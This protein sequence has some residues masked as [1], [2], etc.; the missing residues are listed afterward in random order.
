MRHF[1]TALLSL[2]APV[3]VAA[4]SRTFERQWPLNPDGAVRIHVLYGT[5]RVLGWDKDS[6]SVTGTVGSG[7]EF[8]GGGGR[9]GVKMFVQGDQA[10]PAAEADLLVHV[11]ARA[12]VQV[13]GAA[14]AVDVSAVAGAVDVSTTSGRVNIQG[15]PSQVQAETLGGDLEVTASPGWLRGRTATGRITWTGSSEDV[16]FST[17]TG[18]QTVSAGTVTRARF[19][20][21]DGDVR[22]SGGF[23]R[24]ASLTI[25][26]H[27]GDVT[28]ALRRDVTAELQVDAVTTDLFGSRTTSGTAGAP[29]RTIYK[30][31]GSPGLSGPLVV[32]RSFKGHVTAALQQ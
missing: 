30:S 28:L 8:G 13:R 4:Q 22:F 19:E 24:N 17:V 16:A 5:V 32:V 20:S 2:A 31:L 10:H 9:D 21:I 1:R 3:L 15:T 23:A 14:T 7:A 27:S 29:R 26:T 12:R 11:P 25:D 6:V 18:R